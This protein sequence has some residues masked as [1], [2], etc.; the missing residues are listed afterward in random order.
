MKDLS[1]M[2][3]YHCSTLSPLG[4]LRLVATEKGLC[5]LYM[6]SERHGFQPGADSIEDTHHFSSVIS[7]LDAYFAGNLRQFQ[8]PLDL[9]GTPFQLRAWQALQE[10]PFGETC[11]YGEQAARIG[12]SKAVRAIGLANGKNPVSI[13]V[14]CH[15]VI[16]KT[17]NLTGYGGGLERKRFLLDLESNFLL[18]PGKSG[19]EDFSDLFALRGL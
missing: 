17:G 8:V 16:G 4:R 18:P 11:S 14:P 9:V 6:D 13:I 19:R 15:R 5:G 12:H 10:I 3:T 2:K 1:R 7:Q